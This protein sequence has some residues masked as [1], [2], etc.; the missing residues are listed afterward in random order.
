MLMLGKNNVEEA[1]CRMIFNRVNFRKCMKQ[2][3]HVK[4]V[5]IPT[6]FDLIWGQ[7]LICI[8]ETTLDRF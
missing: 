3:V 6:S 1:E 5:L 8:F 4:S 7:L 2:E